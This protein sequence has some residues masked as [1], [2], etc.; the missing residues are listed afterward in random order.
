MGKVVDKQ[1]PESCLSI[2]KLFQLEVQE[3]LIICDGF[4]HCHEKVAHVV[5][6]VLVELK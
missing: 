3:S 4:C 1:F 6:Y 2:W 5:T